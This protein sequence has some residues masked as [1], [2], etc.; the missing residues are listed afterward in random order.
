MKIFNPNKAS[1]IERL[2]AN[3][4][5]QLGKVRSIGVKIQYAGEIA[6][7]SN[8][9]KNNFGHVKLRLKREIIWLD[10]EKKIK[11]EPVFLELGVA[12]G[13]MTAWWLKPVRKSLMSRNFSYLG[14][15]SFQG[16]P[17][18]WRNFETGAFTTS[19]VLPDVENP[20][21]TFHVGFVEETLNEDL[22]NKIFRGRQI[23]V[24]F[25]LDLFG[26]SLHSYLIIKPFLKEQDIIYFDE[27]R[28]SDERLLLEK[29]VMQDFD[30]MPI[31]ASY[32]NVAFSVIAPKWNL[33]GL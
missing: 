7:F 9:L 23:I 28:D 4:V 16:L 2:V 31:S 22:A 14:F 3:L 26:P 1:L 5:F 32:S 30:L 25:D 11:G 33:M 20:S 18:K 17:H 15:D 27:A 6:D 12:S 10:I 13:Y 29:Y 19:G 24:F 8:F 21:L